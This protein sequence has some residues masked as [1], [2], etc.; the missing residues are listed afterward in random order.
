M[1]SLDLSAIYN[2][3]YPLLAK[4][5]IFRDMTSYVAVV[6]GKNAKIA[7]EHAD[8]TYS[9][10]VAWIP[11]NR[12]SESLQLR[13]TSPDKNLD[14]SRVMRDDF[15]S[16]QQFLTPFAQ[17]VGMNPIQCLGRP[18]PGWKPTAVVDFPT[19]RSSNH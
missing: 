2:V 7:T 12:I 1:Y 5:V 15:G 3:V 10:N 19:L 17:T 4:T 13:G 16:V 6:V 9:G 14:L 8:D 18:P 11:L